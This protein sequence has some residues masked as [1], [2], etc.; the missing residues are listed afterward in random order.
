MQGSHGRVA[1][2]VVSL[3]LSVATRMGGG[4]VHN[5]ESRWDSPPFRRNAVAPPGTVESTSL[6]TPRSSWWPMVLRRPRRTPDPTRCGR[7]RQGR[8]VPSTVFGDA[9]CRSRR[10]LWVVRC[11]RLDWEGFAGSFHWLWLSIRLG[12]VDIHTHI[13][14]H[15]RVLTS[16]GVAVTVDVALVGRAA[17][18][19]TRDAPSCCMEGRHCGGPQA[20]PVEQA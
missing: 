13:H 14:I 6:D 4:L 8:S 9:R 10:C 15:T 19:L 11:S 5:C 2:R 17:E 16:P 3:G 1:T 20:Y 18:F 12:R 7:P